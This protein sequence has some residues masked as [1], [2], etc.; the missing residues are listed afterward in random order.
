MD[1]PDDNVLQFQAGGLD[2]ILLLQEE[3]EEWVC[4][5][6]WVCVCARACAWACLPW[7][8]VGGQRVR[9]HF[10][11]IFHPSEKKLTYVIP[12]EGEEEKVKW[13]GGSVFG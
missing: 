8:Q 10:Q 12:K 9:I 2:L 7:Q 1:Q 6:V 4:V 3:R 11:E 5:C 13:N